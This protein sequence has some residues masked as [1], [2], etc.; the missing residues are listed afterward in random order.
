M[1]N[2]DNEWTNFRLKDNPEASVDYRSQG[3]VIGADGYGVTIRWGERIGFEE[4]RREIKRAL[5]STQLG[6]RDQSAFDAEYGVEELCVNRL[7][8]EEAQSVAHEIVCDNARQTMRRLGW[9]PDNIGGIFVGSS[10]RP[11]NGGKLSE[12]YKNELGFRNAATFDVNAAW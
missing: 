8:E 4:R 11:T 1:G 3:H 6:M 12:V 7:P 2:P 9:E 10:L 5:Q